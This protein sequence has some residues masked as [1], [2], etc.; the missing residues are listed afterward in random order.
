MI[1][2]LLFSRLGRL[3]IITAVLLMG[4]WGAITVKSGG[5]LSPGPVSDTQ[6]EGVMLGGYASHASFEQDCT[7]CHAPIHCITANRCQTCHVEIAQQRLQSNE[8]HGRLPGT[9]RCQT[10]HKEHQGRTAIITHISLTNLDHNLLADFTLERHQVDYVGQDMACADCHTDGQ[11]VATAVNCITCH[12]SADESGMVAHQTLYGTDCVDCHDGHEQTTP[13]DHETVYRLT[14][15][16][17]LVDCIDCHAGQV[18]A[19]TPRECAQCHEEPEMHVDLFGVNCVRCHSTVAWAPAQFMQHS[20]VAASG[21]ESGNE[22]MVSCE[23]CHE[24][25][26]TNYPCYDCHMTHEIR[27]RH[28][29][30]AMVVYENCVDC[31][32]TGRANRMGMVDSDGVENGGATAVTQPKGN[33][34]TP[35]HNGPQGNGGPSS[36]QPNPNSDRPAGNPSPSNPPNNGGNDGRRGK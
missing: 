29:L 12:E 19:E 7:H 30:K 28:N 24:K 1:S 13:F 9:I 22:Q 33:Q 15:A 31:H 18:F 11:F 6:K 14:D 35:P 32:P 8:L 2:Q 36:P 34:G 5:H 23:I 25:N 27:M 16:H 20:F 4:G 3:V 17:E 21:N 10:C 26:Y